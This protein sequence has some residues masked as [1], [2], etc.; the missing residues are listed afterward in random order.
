MLLFTNPEIDVSQLPRAED[1][2]LQPLHPKYLKLLRIEWLITAVVLVTATVLLM[3][4]VPKFQRLP[5]V[6]LLPSGVALFLLFYLLVL[7]K[8]FPHRAYAVR[9]HD[10]VYRKGWL[11]RSL[12]VCP[13]NRIQN[14]T[15]QNGPL[16]RKFGLATLT[17]FTAGSNGADMRIPGLQQ[18]EA[19]DLR[20]FILSRINT[21]ATNI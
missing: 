15:V 9:T 18:T 13:F 14:C 11:V 8:A 5:T 6:W 20:Q 10:V 16:E 7:E 2:L 17:L 12:K 3:V 19:D 21:H 4:F 1:V